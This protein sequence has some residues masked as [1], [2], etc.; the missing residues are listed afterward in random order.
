[1]VQILNSDVVVVL[2]VLQGQGPAL[3]GQLRHPNPTTQAEVIEL[4]A[5]RLRHMIP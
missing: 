3:Q 4:E 1:M 2:A 5:T